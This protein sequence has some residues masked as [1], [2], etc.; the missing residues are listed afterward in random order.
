MK[1]KVTM[2]MRNLIKRSIKMNQQENSEIINSINEI[3]MHFVISTKDQIKKKK[4][5]ILFLSFSSLPSLCMGLSQV[6]DY[7]HLQTKCQC[8]MSSL[9]TCSIFYWGRFSLHISHQSL[10]M[11]S[12]GVAMSPP[13]LHSSLWSKEFPCCVFNLDKENKAS[14]P[15]EKSYL[16]QG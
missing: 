5:I 4:K 8:Q 10:K 11:G 16:Y 7:V 9:A 3:N 12:L 13:T 15:L 14:I 1:C 6:D 2:L